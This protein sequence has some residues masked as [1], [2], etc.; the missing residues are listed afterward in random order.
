MIASLSLIII[1]DKKVLIPL[2]ILISTT[3]NEVSYDKFTNSDSEKKE[4]IN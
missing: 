1:I 2:I 3:F 4:D